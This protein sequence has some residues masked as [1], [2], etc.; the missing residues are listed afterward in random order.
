VPPEQIPLF[1]AAVREAALK[2][3]E[4]SMNHSVRLV[5][6]AIFDLCTSKLRREPS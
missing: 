3:I 5:M 4:A 2:G 6:A 1:S